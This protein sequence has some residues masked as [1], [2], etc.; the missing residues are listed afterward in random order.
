M[1]YRVSV[2]VQS[3]AAQTAP[4]LLGSHLSYSCCSLPLSFYSNITSPA[5]VS[6]HHS[7]I[8]VYDI[9][10]LFLKDRERMTATADGSKTAYCNHSSSRR[11]SK[12]VLLC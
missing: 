12:A 1:K 10:A 5:L 7:Y 8:V 2:R 11:D 6:L 4:G 3:L 9:S